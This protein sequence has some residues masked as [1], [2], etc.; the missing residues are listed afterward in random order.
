MTRK[1]LDL[2][3]TDSDGCLKCSRSKTRRSVV[4][5]GYRRDAR[6]AI[7]TDTPSFQDDQ[8]GVLLIGLHGRILDDVLAECGATRDDVFTT[9]VLR[10]ASPSKPQA[11]EVGACSGY[12]LDTLTALAS[13][14]LRAVI[15]LGQVATQTLCG[16]TARALSWAEIRGRTFERCL[17]SGAKQV[18]RIVPTW[19]PRDVIGNRERFTEMVAHFRY[20]CASLEK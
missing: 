5:G 20:V 9:P 16:L 7:V 15:T 8:H 13:N 2:S 3:L 19:H 10:C 1:A 4:S 11:S 12:L 17:G 14:D 6:L 18:T